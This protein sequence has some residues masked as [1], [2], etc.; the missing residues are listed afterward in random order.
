MAASAS[1]AFFASSTARTASAA[2][3]IQTQKACLIDHPIDADLHDLH[4]GNT[5]RQ[6]LQGRFRASA[7]ITEVATIAQAIVLRTRGVGGTP[8]PPQFLT[9]RVASKVLIGSVG[10]RKDVR[11]NFEDKGRRES[12]QFGEAEGRRQPARNGDD[13]RPS[14]S[15]GWWRRRESNANGAQS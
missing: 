13:T 6:R 11:L 7:G 8:S 12:S 1:A 10:A 5:R 15:E 2:S 9:L 4:C 14:E 3:S